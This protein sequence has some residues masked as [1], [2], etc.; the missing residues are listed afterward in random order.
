M[1]VLEIWGGENVGNFVSNVETSF[2]Q[3]GDVK[4]GGVFLESHVK[5]AIACLNAYFSIL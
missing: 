3:K 1:R 4:K 2:S 5:T